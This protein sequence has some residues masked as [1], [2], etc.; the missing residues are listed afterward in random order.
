VRAGAGCAFGFLVCCVQ[1]YSR[2]M[3][4][5]EYVCVC[6]CVCVY[7]YVLCVFMGLHV[8]LCVC[9]VMYACIYACVR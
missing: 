7:G 4:S 6:M 5:V 9:K 2:G 3:K 8:C 1:P